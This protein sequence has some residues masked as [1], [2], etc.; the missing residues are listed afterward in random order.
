MNTL[1]EMK[2][3][4][5]LEVIIIFFFV[6]TLDKVLA[7]H[8]L[9]YW[10]FVAQLPTCLVLMLPGVV[11]VLAQNAP[12]SGKSISQKGF[13]KLLCYVKVVSRTNPS[14]YPLLLLI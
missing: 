8:Q 9:A 3:L 14:T 13:I 7:G 6:F 1:C 11:T 10:R 12:N 4:A 2:S 5:F